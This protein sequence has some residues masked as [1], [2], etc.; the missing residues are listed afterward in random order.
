M[1]PPGS[2]TITFLF[3][4]IEGS[5]QRWEGHPQVM[6]AAQVRHDQILTHAVE[7]HN[8][9]LFKIVGDSG[10]AAFSNA[11]DGL[12][13]ALAAQYAIQAEAWPPEIAPLKVRMALHTGFAELQ[14]GDYAG[15]ALNRVAR[16][17]SAGHGGQILLCNV[18]A[19]LLMSLNRADIK[20][21]YLGSHQLK[22]LT[23]PAE[24]YQA[25]VPGRQEEFPPLNSL[26]NRPHNLP[27][28][29]TVF[30][31]R[32]K[33]LAEA[34]GLLS[35]CRLLTL[36][37]PGGTGKT[38]LGLQLAAEVSDEFED[39]TYFIPLASIRNAALIPSAIAQGLGLRE[40]AER[41]V[42]ESLKS[43]LHENRILLLVDNF[44]HVI[45]AAPLMSELL[46]DAHWL[47][48][49]T[50]SREALRVY[51]EQ[52]YY[53]EP[54]SVPDADPDTPVEVLSRNEAV[55]LFIQRASSVAPNFRI[56]G[57]NAL[58]VVQIC[59]RL[60]GLPLAIELAAARVRLFPPQALLQ[61][62]D[63]RLPVLTSK[64]RDLPERQQT[65]RETLQWSYDL[66][67]PGEQELFAR[68]GIFNG[69][70]TLEAV[71]AICA[72]GLD[73][74]SVDGLESLLNKSL[75]RTQEGQAGVRFFHARDDPRVRP[76][77]PGGAWR[78][79]EPAGAASA[80]SPAPGRKGKPR[81]HGIAATNLVRDDR[82]RAEQYSC[83]A[84]LVLF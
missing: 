42:I 31:G 7:S 8:G 26:S 66:L 10:H 23:Q 56:S 71:E 82:S 19:A 74:D 24:I 14:D 32:Q 84:G 41:P 12:S 60:D 48:I 54:L 46:A 72:P 13:A 81:I 16:I 47:K 57:E 18:T 73:I 6:S 49:V 38:R 51:G 64:M 68:L 3:T 1:N 37:G 62:L 39:G 78:G 43:Y 28:L 35:T 4:D 45:E 11:Q 20:L 79:K 15:Q 29:P 77:A 55:A 2:G 34:R 59:R 30:I 40:S 53:V 70:C 75:L 52:V 22:D 61:R 65:L 27:I 83:C 44:E 25:L 5:T 67:D 9:Y 63:K 69:G 17:L 21:K 58:D 33:E 80:V 36:T 76:R 50:T